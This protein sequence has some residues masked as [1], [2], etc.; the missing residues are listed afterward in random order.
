MSSLTSYSILHI[1]PYLRPTLQL[2]K[3]VALHLISDLMCEL[4]A[5][6]YKQEHRQYIIPFSENM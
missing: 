2:V 1:Q 4:P 3:K 6:E 5:T